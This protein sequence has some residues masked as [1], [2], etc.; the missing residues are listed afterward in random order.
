MFYDKEQ[1]IST[2][3]TIEHVLEKVSTT[4]NRLLTWNK[5][6]HRV[7][8]S[9]SFVKMAVLMLVKNACSWK[10]C[11]LV[12]DYHQ[13]SPP[14][15]HDVGEVVCWRE[16]ICSLKIICM[17]VNYVGE[18]FSVCW[19]KVFSLTV[20]MLVKNICWWNMYV[21]KNVI[22]LELLPAELNDTIYKI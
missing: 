17:L 6:S 13:H 20:L 3:K 18:N 9:I 4:L 5:P 22:S 14:K 12:K 21:G 2:N 16:K 8:R 10:I 15:L 1:S 11:M 19:R 7:F